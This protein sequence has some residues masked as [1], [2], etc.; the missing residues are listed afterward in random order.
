MEKDVD[1]NGFLGIAWGTW[2][3]IIVVAKGAWDI[4]KDR[5]KPKLDMATLQGQINVVASQ[6]IA[7]SAKLRADLKIENTELRQELKE[8]GEKY[9]VLSNK[10]DILV[11]ENTTLKESRQ[12]LV[13]DIAQ[14]KNALVE[15]QNQQII[16]DGW[17]EEARQETK[18]L[19]GLVAS[20]QADNLNLQTQI[21]HLQAP[22]EAAT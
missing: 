15:I 17:L 9:E 4:W 3:I 7:D 21:N 12:V 14:L 8:F 11:L 6:N 19:T 10:F 2:A 22:A 1:A 18:R 13:G 16:K 20:L 5:N